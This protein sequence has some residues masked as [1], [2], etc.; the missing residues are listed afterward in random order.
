M[1]SDKLTTT[2]GYANNNI[3]LVSR[4]RLFK[5]MSLVQTLGSPLSSQLMPSNFAMRAIDTPSSPQRLQP[6]TRAGSPRARGGSGIGRNG[7]IAPG[8]FKSIASGELFLL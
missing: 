4:H 1:T 2:H 8:S 6:G 5:I 7:G 3:L